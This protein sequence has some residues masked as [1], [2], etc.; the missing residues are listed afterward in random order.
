MEYGLILKLYVVL[1]L[2]GYVD[3]LNLSEYVALV[4]SIILLEALVLWLLWWNRGLQIRHSFLKMLFLSLIMNLMTV[5]LVPLHPALFWTFSP[6][7]IVE[8]VPIAIFLRKYKSH[9]V[10]LDAIGS[11]VIVNVV[12]SFLVAFVLLSHE[13]DK[14]YVSP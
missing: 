6:N 11:V 5:F 12:S 3:V 10:L 8:I 4:A 14:S 1:N 7:L 9:S 2:T 13:G